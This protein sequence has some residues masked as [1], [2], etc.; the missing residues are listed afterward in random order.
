VNSP[1]FDVRV[2]LRGRAGER[3]G[4]DLLVAL[5][6]WL[7]NGTVV[8]TQ[9]DERGGVRLLR[10]AALLLLENGEVR[11]RRMLG[12]FSG[13]AT[14]HLGVLAVEHPPTD[15]PTLPGL[16]GSW[17]VTRATPALPDEL[18]MAAAGVDLSRLHKSLEAMAWSGLLRVGEDAAELWREGAVVAARAGKEQ[19]PDALPGLRRA[20]A[21]TGATLLLQ[22]LDGRTSAALLGLS[23]GA[24]S[25]A[26]PH[27]ALACEAE[28]TLHLS[29]GERDF[30]VAGGS[31][32]QGV[33]R[34][35]E[36]AAGAPLQPPAPEAEA[37]LLGQRFALTLR[38][39]DAL[40]PMTDRWSAFHAVFGDA[41][42]RVLEAVGAGDAL[43]LVA[44]TF[45]LDHSQLGG[46]V[47]AWLRDGLVR[48]A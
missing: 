18:R 28:R 4:Q 1:L 12:R 22:P 8:F 23:D 35:S 5:K 15:L 44:R 13:L 30:A 45:E 11:V 48:R 46:W 25:E 36:R 9:S 17:A 43:D 37:A 41:G 26:G 33:F 39:R 27:A 16:G 42:V 31:G 6:A 38:G 32:V 34:A 14:T 3:S 29:R 20:A 21:D 24:S 2:A 7:P 10:G 40:N 19:G 47:E